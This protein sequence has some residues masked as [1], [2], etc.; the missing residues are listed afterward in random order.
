MNDFPA[1]KSSSRPFNWPKAIVISSLLAIP[2][3]FA[4]YARL[5]GENHFGQGLEDSLY[6]TA[7]WAVQMLAFFG[8]TLSP[9]LRV[10]S[11]RRQGLLMIL[12]ILGFFVAEALSFVFIAFSFPE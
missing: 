6:R 9:C 7:F 8:L 11:E 3:S 2:A 5:S 12:A 1:E 10:Q 4:I